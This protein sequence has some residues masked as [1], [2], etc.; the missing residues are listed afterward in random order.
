MKTLTVKKL[1]IPAVMAT[2]VV[3]CAEMQTPQSLLSAQKAYQVAAKDANVQK[4]A[5]PE[6]NKA[7]V[8][9]AKAAMAESTEDMT[10]LAYIG[11]AQVETAIQQA[12]AKQANQNSKDLLAKKDQLIASSISA[13]KDRAQQKLKAMQAR[14]AERDIL[15]AFGQIEFV[16]GMA[17]L[18]AGASKGI[19]MLADYMG[20]YSA[21]TVSLSGH[22]DSSGSAKKNQEL[23]QQRADFIRNVLISKGVSAER[24]TAIGYGQS[25]PIESNSS[26]AGRQKNRRI[27]IKF[28]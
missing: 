4:Y 9:L 25:Q 6:L 22:T 28:N 20:S 23:S 15:L 19:D 8:T 11:N 17:D 27:E 16:T 18:V 7:N 24:I 5:L 13:Q 3:G 1:I 26:R 2:L 14:E 21:K 12:A 10:S